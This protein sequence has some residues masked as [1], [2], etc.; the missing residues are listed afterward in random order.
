[1]SDIGGSLDD[2]KNIMLDRTDLVAQSKLVP[3]TTIHIQKE[4][5]AV[6]YKQTMQIG[7]Y[8]QA[9][10]DICQDHPAIITDRIWQKAV[11]AR[12]HNA[13]V[14]ATKM[15]MKERIRKAKTKEE[16]VEAARISWPFMEG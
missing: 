12:K 16:V 10:I 5:E 11:A 15:A 8:L 14:E 2:Y 9:E 13:L 6:L 3:V 1:M 4:A 7:V